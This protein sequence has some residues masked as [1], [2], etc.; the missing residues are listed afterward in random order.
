MDKFLSYKF[1]SIKEFDAISSGMFCVKSEKSIIDHFSLPHI[2]VEVLSMSKR[3]MNEVM[4]VAEDNNIEIYYQDTDSMHIDARKDENGIDGVTKL[5]NIFREQYGKELVGKNLGQFHSDFS[6]KKAKN[7]ESIISVESVYVGKKTYCDK[8]EVKYYDENK[9]EKIVYDF[10]S[11]M[12]G[13]PEKC[14]L[15]KS[16]LLYNN[17]TLAMYDDLLSGKAIE[18]DLLE[19]CKF[20]FKNNFTTIN[21]KIFKR[22]LKF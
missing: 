8:L 15:N 12:K 20:A 1:N 9:E 11:R 14:I 5:T 7:P 21:N 6:T 3:I 4:C 16:E 22:V 10:H 18:F 19:V 17:N 13:I 2:G